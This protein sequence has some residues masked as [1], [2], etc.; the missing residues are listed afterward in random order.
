MSS[1][2]QATTVASA[3]FTS[4]SFVPILTK[5]P[6]KSRII[7]VGRKLLS[8]LH[9]NQVLTLFYQVSALLMLFVTY[10]LTFYHTVM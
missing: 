8:S 7:H 4:F 5:L 1:L 6:A 10:S 2:I 9:P 3:N